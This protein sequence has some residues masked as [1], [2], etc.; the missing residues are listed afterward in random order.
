MTWKQ[1]PTV[2]LL[3]GEHMQLD[4]AFAIVE[5][6]MQASGISA[7]TLPA[8]QFPTSCGAVEDSSIEQGKV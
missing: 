7:Q 5:R 1:M 2:W 4:G 8:D 6:R 3:S